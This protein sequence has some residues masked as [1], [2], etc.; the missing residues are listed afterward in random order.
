[1]IFNSEKNVNMFEITHLI[2]ELTHLKFT[3]LSSG[4]LPQ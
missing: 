3:S 2:L 1:M 4:F